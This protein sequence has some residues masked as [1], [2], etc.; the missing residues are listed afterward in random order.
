MNARLLYHMARADFLERAR[1]YSFLA[2]VAGAV[3]FGYL[4]NAGDV[5]LTLKGQR[6]I[7]NSAWVGTLTALAAGL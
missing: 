7:L 4:I 1:R 6:G 5:N 2:T 3:Y